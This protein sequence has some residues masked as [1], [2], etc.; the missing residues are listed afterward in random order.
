V[1]EGN[2]IEALAKYKDIRY[3]VSTAS[4]GWKIVATGAGVGVRT[5]ETI[6]I[7]REDERRGRIRE[8]GTACGALRK[9][10]TSAFLTGPA[11]S[12]QFTSRP[13]CEAAFCA[14]AAKAIEQNES[15][16]AT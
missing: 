12:E 16:T 3:A 5:R 2:K 15:T 13:I 14:L 11:R 7:K 4:R 1:V 9:R 10:T 8:L 6:E